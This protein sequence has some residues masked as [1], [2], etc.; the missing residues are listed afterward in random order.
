MSNSQQWA[1][2]IHNDSKA[3]TE[4]LM[5]N[6][7]R[8]KVFRDDPGI[9]QKNPKGAF[10]EFLRCMNETVDF[11]TDMKRKYVP[12][13][14]NSGVDPAA[15]REVK[16]LQEKA[17]S[18]EDRLAEALKAKD[19]ALN[20]LS[21]IQCRLLKQGNPDIADLSD[22]NRPTNLGQ[23]FK[24]LYEDEWTDA[25]TFLTESRKKRISDE[26]AVETLYKLVQKCKS[27]C[28]EGVAL[29]SARVAELVISPDLAGSPISDGQTPS[30]VNQLPAQALTPNRALNI[31]M[32]AAG[33]NPI[34]TGFASSMSA[35]TRMRAED[36]QTQQFSKTFVVRRDKS[37]EQQGQGKEKALE[38][39]IKDFC[40]NVA[41][42]VIEQFNIETLISKI[43]STQE[44]PADIFDNKDVI[45]FLT[46]CV[47]LCWLMQ[48]QYPPMMLDFSHKPGDPSNKDILTAYSAR[49]TRIAFIVWPPVNLHKGGPLVSKGYAEGKNP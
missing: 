47:R 22:D 44:F 28:E 21:D 29:Q 46:K 9:I 49:G 33:S 48:S 25:L 10:D 4:K 14:K 17:Q 40:K 30:S 13:A 39:A 5:E 32:N 36:V 11:C 43:N 42:L 38:G 27:L 26:K 12:D 20:R 6:R 16:R 34:R 8:L 23:N 2:R 15:S 24:G 7:K 41:P 3:A 31:P 1:Q 35:A 18:L 37:I 19:Q 45:K